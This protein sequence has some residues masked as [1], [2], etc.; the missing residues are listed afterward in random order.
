MNILPTALQEVI[1]ALGSLPGVGP[2]SAERYAYFL[3]KNPPDITVRLG[4]SLQKLHDNV[5]YC[6]K[7][8]ALVRK[9]Q[10]VSELYS[11]PSRNKQL[12]AVV[13]EPFDI[14]ALEKT[15]QFK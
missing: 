5:G 6:R 10:E 11:D 7:T 13:A 3:L 2:R 1:E 14:A 12:V 4:D 9:G 8:F 15:G